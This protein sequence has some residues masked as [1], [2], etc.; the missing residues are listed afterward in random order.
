MADC[1]DSTSFVLPKT[2]DEYKRSFKCLFDQ[3]AYKE[4]KIMVMHS[5]GVMPDSSIICR[6]AIRV[7]TRAFFSA[8]DDYF[9]SYFSEKCDVLILGDSHARTTFGHLVVDR[10]LPLA[11]CVIAK[12]GASIIGFGRKDSSLATFKNVYRFIERNNPAHVVLKL[13]QVDMDLGVYFRMVVKDEVIDFQ[14]FLM[15]HIEMYINS[16]L[17]LPAS[18]RYYVCGVNLP[19]LFDQASAVKYTSRV[20]TQNIT[21][22]EAVRAA[23]FKLEKL[24]P[25]IAIRTKITLLFN[26]I[27]KEFAEKNGI[28][29]FDYTDYLSDV[30]TGMLK[31]RYE[32]S[33]DH[34]IAFDREDQKFIN[35]RL[36]GLLNV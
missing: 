27:L 34:H 18:S 36:F 31:A 32:Q 25:K 20:V 13:G 33:D 4:A 11:P 6:D 5:V 21:D 3:E 26:A 9:S 29:Y 7:D 24:L 17:N 2:E 12:S 30:E 14:E 1:P 8:D 16:V 19:C 22:E 15:R 10:G 35:A 28:E 23:S